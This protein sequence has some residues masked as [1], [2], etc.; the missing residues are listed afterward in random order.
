MCKIIIEEVFVKKFIA[1]ATIFNE[2]FSFARVICI[3][4]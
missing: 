4:K 3:Y 1:N 2:I